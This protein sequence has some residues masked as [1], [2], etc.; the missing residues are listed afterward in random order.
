[1][2]TGVTLAVRPPG[3]WKSKLEKS[4]D[5]QLKEVGR[6]ESFTTIVAL[7]TS[8]NSG[9]RRVTILVGWSRV[10]K[11]LWSSRTAD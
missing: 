8:L 6:T 4:F 2:G 11:V 10:G 9:L 1:M 5:E 7:L 3:N